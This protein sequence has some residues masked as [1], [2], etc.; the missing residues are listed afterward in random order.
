M[1][2]SK[3]SKN[4]QQSDRKWVVVQLS[5]TGECE[6][7]LAILEKAVRRYTGPLEVFI[8]AAYQETKDDVRNDSTTTFYMDGYIFVEFKDGVNYGRLNETTYFVTVLMTGKK[9]HLLSDIHLKPLRAGVERLK[10]KEGVFE[11]GDHVKVIQGSFKNLVGVVSMVYD[12]EEGGKKVLVSAGLVSK[13][14]L[15]DFHS[16]YLQKIIMK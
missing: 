8:P 16:T 13:P 11:K 14:Q 6:K 15:L 4:E 3:G 12:G 2:S 10:I 7:D 9:L 5:P 1:R